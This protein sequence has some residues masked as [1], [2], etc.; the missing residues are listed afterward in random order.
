MPSLQ[1]L[2]VRFSM[3]FS[4]Y[5]INDFP[6]WL[7]VHPLHLRWGRHREQ[8][9]R[10]VG[11]PLRAAVLNSGLR[12]LTLVAQENGLRT[13]FKSS[14]AWAWDS[15]LRR[16]RVL[17]QISNLGNLQLCR[18]WSQQVCPMALTSKTGLRWLW[19]GRWTEGKCVFLTVSPSTD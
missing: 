10:K 4:L 7:E 12:S 18:L 6:W 2:G 9:L 19:L 1:F 3:A 15:D 8:G 11:R 14:K 16:L 17:S 13:F 5:W